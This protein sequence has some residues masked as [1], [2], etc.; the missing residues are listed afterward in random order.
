MQL[1]YVNAHD[2]ILLNLY[3]YDRITSTDLGLCLKLYV[4]SF[5]RLCVCVFVRVC[6]R[7]CV[8]WLWVCL[9]MYLCVLHHTIVCACAG[10]GEG[11]ITCTYTIRTLY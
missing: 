4:C 1:H 9:C 3:M 5:A 8:V 7:V 11:I 6:V 10:G 2:C